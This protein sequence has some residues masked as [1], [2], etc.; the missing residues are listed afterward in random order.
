V[1]AVQSTISDAEI[2]TFKNGLLSQEEL[3]NQHFKK[4]KDIADVAFG[5]TLAETQAKNDAIFTITADHKQALLDLEREEF[6]IDEDLDKAERLRES[7]QTERDILIQS[8]EDRQ[9][10]LEEG[11]QLLVITEQEKNALI[12]Q[13]RQEHI[14]ALAVIDAQELS[15]GGDI[16]NIEMIRQS[17]MSERD[18][19][20]EHHE[21]R[22][23]MI[24][25]AFQDG[26]INLESK[27]ALL[28]SLNKDHEEKIT[29][30]KEKEANN[31]SRIAM[32]EFNSALSAFA[33]FANNISTLMESSGRD[34]H[35][36]AKK[37]SKSAIAINSIQSISSSYKAGA[38]IGGPYVGAAFAVIA[39]AATQKQQSQLNSISYGGGGSSGG[40]GG[41]T[42]SLPTA[43]PA[44]PIQPIQQD[45]TQAPV[46]VIINGNVYGV[47]DLNGLV[48]EAI[49]DASSSDRITVTVVDSGERVK[50]A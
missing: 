42:P 28:E 11:V 40:G 18:V 23:F 9:F 27:K 4:Q 39:L 44:Q 50:I 20:A 17:L 41:G 16:N 30:D 10:D 46:Q 33:G 45:Q 3:L 13:L 24:E 14:D 25:D 21:I 29:A 49:K 37:R 32:A 19:L 5:K 38:D 12:Q 31:R 2:E 22:Q 36:K 15:V 47:D 34:Q 26:L 7:L 6:G 8:F 35:G 1:K 48:E 43:P